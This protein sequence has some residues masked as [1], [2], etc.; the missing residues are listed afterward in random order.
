[1][2]IKSELIRPFGSSRIKNRRV[3]K[4]FKTM[5]TTI[6]F[7]CFLTVS[8]VSEVWMQLS[9][10]FLPMNSFRTL[11]FLARQSYCARMDLL[12]NTKTLRTGQRIKVRTANRK[13]EGWRD[14]RLCTVGD[15]KS[16]ISRW[17]FMLILTVGVVRGR[18]VHLKTNK[19]LIWK[20][21]FDLEMI[22][23]LFNWI[24]SFKESGLVCFLNRDNYFY[25]M[26]N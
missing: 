13:N 7:L 14:H 9:W 6:Q 23:F 12:C 20:N 11:I 15:T 19:Y 2:S 17:H 18:N 21:D 24:D 25:C 4:S 8:K 3:S 10:L 1:M 22:N 5:Y 26:S 16:E